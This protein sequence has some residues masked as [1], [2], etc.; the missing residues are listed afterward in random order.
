MIKNIKKNDGPFP[1]Q[2][3]YT[4]GNQEYQWTKPNPAG[5]KNGNEGFVQKR[6]S[7]GFFMVRSDKKLRTEKEVLKFINIDVNNG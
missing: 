4:V 6:N 2:K 1:D 7:E 3:R 5:V